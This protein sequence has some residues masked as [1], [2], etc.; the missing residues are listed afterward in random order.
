[1]VQI[2]N[3]DLKNQM[4]ELPK[5]LQKEWHCVSSYYSSKSDIEVFEEFK[6]RLEQFEGSSIQEFLNVSEVIYTEWSFWKYKNNYDTDFK[7]IY[8]NKITQKMFTEVWNEFKI[9]WE[10]DSEESKVMFKEME[11][12]SKNMLREWRMK[13]NFEYPHVYEKEDYYNSNSNYKL[14]SKIHLWN[15]FKEIWE[16][17]TSNYNENKYKKMIEYVN[18]IECDGED[19]FFKFRENANY[20]SYDSYSLLEQFEICE[21]YEESKTESDY[22]S[23]ESYESY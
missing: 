2:I 7:T 9:F 1:M 3:T 21:D 11:L 22:E 20:H 13:Y 5:R 4:A 14:K 18:R 15:E 10:F 19:K 16:I 12:L 17:D 23:D 8:N 6:K